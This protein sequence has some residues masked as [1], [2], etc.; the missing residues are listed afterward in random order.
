M[1]YFSFFFLISFCLSYS[2][3]TTNLNVIETEE[4]KDELKAFVMLA[5][6]TTDSNLT[7]AIRG[8]K[9]KFAIS[10][11]NESFKETISKNIKKES[12]EYFKESF[13]NGD[14]LYF[15]SVYSPKKSIKQINCYTYNLKSNS[16]K[17]E[18]LIETKID[19]VNLLS[20]GVKKRKTYFKLSKNGQFFAIAFDTYKKNSNA[21]AIKVFNTKNLK[22]VYEHSFKKFEKKHFTPNDVVVDDKGVVYI[23]GKLYMLGKSEKKLLSNEANYEFIL[24]KISQNGSEY[25]NVNL[26][27]QHIRSL[28]M[29]DKTKTIFLLGLMSDKNVYKISSS[30]NF[31]VKK[32]PFEI[33]DKKYQKLPQQVYENLYRAGRIERIKNRNLASFPI[34]YLIEDDNG[35]SFILAEKFYATYR[36]VYQSGQSYRQPTYHYDD[37]I[38][39][40]F[41]KAGNLAWGSS[42]Y[43][44]S[45]T[46]SY[47]AFMK[48]DNLHVLFNASK[49]LIKTKDGRVK[50]K[51]K[52]LSRPSLY[53]Y[54]YSSDGEVLR[55]KIK[56]K[57][58]YN[59]YYGTAKDNKFIMMR[60]G[61]TKR[62]L[63]LK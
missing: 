4:T 7:I 13:I 50:A 61:K 15:F 35:N 25:L 23:L 9:K 53:D 22:L 56:D 20:S 37:I 6:E 14:N 18:L 55:T 49:D 34:D 36:T 47:N 32:M 42:I 16:L 38:I 10:V 12:K 29:V 26:K 11:F 40:K 46:P 24:N 57:V 39:L 27:D 63:I 62:F 45:I 41:D 48:N 33:T 43:K 19:G 54:E 2:Q 51:Q 60:Y 28:R 30:C 17:K 59:A 44:K 58:R 3:N 8:D 5:I 1:K 31:I 52:I 21:Y